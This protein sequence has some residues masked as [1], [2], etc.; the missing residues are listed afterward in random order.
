MGKLVFNKFGWAVVMTT[1]VIWSWPVGEAVSEGEKAYV[2]SNACEDCHESEFEK[3]QAYA[4]KAHSFEKI[5]VMKKG[6]TDAEFQSCFE[7]HT[8][9][10]GQP[11][12]FRSEHETP[13]LKD[14]GCEVCHGPG[15][16][17]CE[18][19]DPADIIGSLTADDCESCHRSDRVAAFDYKPL[20]YGGAH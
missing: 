16:L 7:C 17:H 4:K 20:I 8:T 15:S 19:E 14:A 6:L 18:T 3:F 5:K 9:G 11:G 13:E 2:G 1:I 10:Y 12:G